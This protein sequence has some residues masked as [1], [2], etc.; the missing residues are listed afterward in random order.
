[1]FRQIVVNTLIVRMTLPIDVHV[2]QCPHCWWAGLFKCFNQEFMEVGV[3][4]V[5]V[6]GHLVVN[7]SI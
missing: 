3:S 1:M 6:D 4:F 2:I 5:R 7:R